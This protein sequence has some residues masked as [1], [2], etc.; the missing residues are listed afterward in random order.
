MGRLNDGVFKLIVAM[1]LRLIRY[2][3]NGQS[4]LKKQNRLVTALNNLKNPQK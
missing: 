1:T 2:A 4:T 3:L